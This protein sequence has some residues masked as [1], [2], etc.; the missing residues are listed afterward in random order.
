M[1]PLSAEQVET[2]ARIAHEV[3]R[4]YCHFFGD[5]RITPPA[6]DHSASLTSDYPWC[7]PRQPAARPAG[8]PTSPRCRGPKYG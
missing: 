6:R 3:N 7:K 8:L 2:A 1:F 4:A 5:T